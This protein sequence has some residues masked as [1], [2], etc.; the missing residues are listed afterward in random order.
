MKYTYQYDVI[1]N[2]LVQYVRISHI[3]QASE[4]KPGGVKSALQYSIDKH[5]NQGL[6]RYLALYYIFTGTSTTPC[7]LNLICF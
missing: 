4:V 5:Q 6:N 7:S 3:N 2:H 1:P